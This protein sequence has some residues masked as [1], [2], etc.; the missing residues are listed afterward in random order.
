[1]LCVLRTLGR[2]PERVRVPSGTRDMQAL[3][4]ERVGKC[5]AE[6][7]E[8]GAGTLWTDMEFFLVV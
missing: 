3:L 4:L 6:G 7:N 2:K 8:P 1:M 5:F